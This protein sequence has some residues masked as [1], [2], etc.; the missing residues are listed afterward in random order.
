MLTWEHNN[1]IDLRDTECEVLGCTQLAQD[2]VHEHDGRSVD[3]VSLVRIP[4]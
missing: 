3:W 4:N 2:M 1:K